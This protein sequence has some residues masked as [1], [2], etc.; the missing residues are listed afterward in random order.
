MQPPFWFTVLVLYNDVK[1][2]LLLFIPMLISAYGSSQNVSRKR[3]DNYALTI[4]VYIYT[5]IYMFVRIY[6]IYTCV[7]VCV[8]YKSDIRTVTQVL[9]WVQSSRNYINI[10]GNDAYDWVVSLTTD[11]QRLGRRGLRDE[12]WLAHVHT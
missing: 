10:L 4:K 9:K 2:N 3:N 11:C 1:F 12:I 7:Y 5:H 8:Y 6:F